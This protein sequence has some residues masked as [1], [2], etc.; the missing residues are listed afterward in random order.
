MCAICVYV[1]IAPY[2]LIP[3]S[4][5]YLFLSLPISLSFPISRSHHIEVEQ[6][7]AWVEG[8]GLRPIQIGPFA[9]SATVAPHH[10]IHNEVADGGHRLAST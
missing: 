2:L 10:V 9:A 6:Q 1:Y 5:R 8:P 4:C 7:V 3:L